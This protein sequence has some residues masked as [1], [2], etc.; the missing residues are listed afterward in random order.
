MFNRSQGC[1]RRQFDT[2]RHQFLQEPKGKDRHL[3][4]A[5]Y[6]VRAKQKRTSR[7]GHALTL[8]ELQRSCEAEKDGGSQFSRNGQ[9]RPYL[10]PPLISRGLT[11]FRA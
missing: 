6:N 4:C 11:R 2:L 8:R 3:L 1:L 9:G 10:H 5:I 7:K